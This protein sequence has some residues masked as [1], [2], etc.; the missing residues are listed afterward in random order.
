[1]LLA[2]WIPFST[3]AVMEPFGGGTCS[4][5]GRALPIQAVQM[6]TSS[7]A[8]RRDVS[9][10]HHVGGGDVRVALAAQTYPPAPSR[11]LGGFR[12]T[13]LPP[14]LATRASFAGSSVRLR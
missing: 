6:A 11:S 7:R 5:S 4:P 12:S 3:G 8:V 1:M 13:M 10:D 9:V 2:V 14:P